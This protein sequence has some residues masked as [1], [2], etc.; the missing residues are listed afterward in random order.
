MDLQEMTVVRCR[1]GVAQKRSH[2]A[3]QLTLD[4][5]EWTSKDRTN[6]PR[7]LISFY[8]S[9]HLKRRHLF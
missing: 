2:P 5:A 9:I 4:G 8:N 6:P 7:C 3:L 1:R